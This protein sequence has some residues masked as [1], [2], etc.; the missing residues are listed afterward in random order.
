MK[1][2]DTKM[3]E[4]PFIYLSGRTYLPLSPK[5]KMFPES[6][7]EEKGDKIIQSFGKDL[8]LKFD[9]S[10]R[11]VGMRSSE[12][13]SPFSFTKTKLVD[14]AKIPFDGKGHGL[15]WE[16]FDWVYRFHL[17]VDQSDPILKIFERKDEYIKSEEAF[18]KAISHWGMERWGG[19]T[20][21]LSIDLEKLIRTD[22]DVFWP[23]LLSKEDP[24]S[25]KKIPVIIGM[26]SHKPD[27]L[28]KLR[29]EK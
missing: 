25:K 27:L 23:K 10:P 17:E 8:D 16:V 4:E 9:S 6:L 20:L 29:G 3:P 24:L 26:Y 21:E 2:K 22:I 7:T 19:L 18:E 15:E 13:Y 5:E 12:M 11:A 1:Y 14:Y 28:L